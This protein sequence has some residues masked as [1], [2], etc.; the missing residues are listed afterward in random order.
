MP[1]KIVILDGYAENPGDLSWDGIKVQGETTIYD[2]TAPEDVICRIGDADCIFTNKVQITKEIMDACPTV[3][4]IGELATGF[5]NIDVAA[6][7]ERGI[8]VTNIPSYATE[9]VVQFTFGLIFE[10]CF[11][12]GAHN[13]SVHDGDWQ[14]C[15]DF[16][17]TKYPMTELTGKT[18]GIVGMGRIGMG[19][20]KVA[21]ALGMRV[22]AHSGHVKPEL[23]GSL[24]HFVSF[25]ELLE[26]SDVVSIHC[27]QTPTNGGMMNR[28]AFSHMKDGAI[29][30]NT[31]RGGLVVEK[32]LKEA[33]DSGKLSGA[34]VDVVSKEPIEAE[35]P[36][37]TAKNLIIT[38][39]IA[40][41]TKEARQ[42]LMDVAVQNLASYLKGQPVNVV[43]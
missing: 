37:L 16:T 27:P 13:Q 11:Q 28:E 29:F 31:G 25:E 2:R 40:W 22:L 15:K 32:D 20:A 39:H 24:C 42:R 36:L 10:L 18:I 7:K 9:T 17:Y 43:S 35:N 33:L 8:T 26:Q 23:E 12:I 30:I 34:A 6:A 4:Y 1:H 3:K 21:N 19:V 14:N 5:N 38:P 41:E